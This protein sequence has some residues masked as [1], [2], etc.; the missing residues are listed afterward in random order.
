MTRISII[1]PSIEPVEAVRNFL[2]YI[3]EQIEDREHAEIIFVDASAD[4][5]TARYVT[6][7]GCR[8]ITSEKMR[9]AFQL[10]L[11]AAVA[12]YEVLFFMHLDSYPPFG[13]DTYVRSAIQGDASSGSFVLGFKPSHWFLSFSAWFTR[14]RIGVARGGDQGLFVTKVRFL[15]VGGYKTAWQ[16]LED[17][18]LARKLLAKGDYKIIIGTRMVTSSRRYAE[19]GIFKL[20]FLFGTIMGMYYFG[21]SNKAI[22]RFYSQKI[23]VYHPQNMPNK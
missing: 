17:V 22:W 12:R 7:L 4:E 10:N 14:F 20:Q 9:K 18:D 1:I 8:H 5:E 2:P 13:F 3:L 6:E 21:I 15:E 23:G 19:I 16:V 11:G